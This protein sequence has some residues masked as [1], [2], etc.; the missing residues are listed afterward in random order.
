MDERTAYAML[1]GDLRAAPTGSLGGLLIDGTVLLLSAGTIDPRLRGHWSIGLA[2]GSGATAQPPRAA[3]D[4]LVARFTQSGEDR[5]DFVARAGASTT[6]LFALLP[7]D[8]REE[9]A[10]LSFSVGW[11]VYSGTTACSLR[12][13]VSLALEP[14]PDLPSRINA[15]FANGPIELSQLPATRR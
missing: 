15:R 8:S 9:P 11:R 12:D 10:R 6:R 2:S 4:A 5:W 7:T 3:I 13:D 14:G 1:S